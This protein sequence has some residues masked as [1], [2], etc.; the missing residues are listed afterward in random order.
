MLLGFCVGSGGEGYGFCLI[1]ASYF[2][3]ALGQLTLY[4]GLFV[5]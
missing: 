4:C 3:V 2:L 1:G 5:P